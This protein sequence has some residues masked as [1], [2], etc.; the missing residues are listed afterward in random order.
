MRGELQREDVE[1]TMKEASWR[2][3]TYCVLWSP[4]LLLVLLSFSE[5]KAKGVHSAWV[6]QTSLHSDFTTIDFEPFLRQL[7]SDFQRLPKDSRK[8][9]NFTAS[10]HFHFWVNQF[11]YLYSHF[12]RSLSID[13]LRR[14]QTN[15]QLFKH[16]YF[17]VEA[18]RNVPVC[19]SRSTLW[20]GLDCSWHPL[21]HLGLLTIGF[22]GSCRV[23]QKSV[24]AVHCIVR[25]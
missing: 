3:I 9:F 5:T 1:H 13:V 25:Q 12:D 22:E 20:A 18:L 19:T 8:D 6:P 24:L 7:H 2:L 21:V 15:V 4:I 11:I 17:L 23:C 10:S 14:T 16:F